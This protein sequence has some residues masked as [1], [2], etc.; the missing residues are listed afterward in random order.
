MSGLPLRCIR[1]G[2]NVSG[3]SDKTERYRITVC[4]R[5]QISCIIVILDSVISK[6]AKRARRSAA[7]LQPLRATRR[8]RR[9][10]DLVQQQAQL[11]N[12][13]HDAIV[14]RNLNCEILYWN[15]GAEATYGW[16]A[17]AVLGQVSHQL[18]STEFPEPREAIDAQVI[19][20]GRWEGEI[21]H[22]RADGTVIV[23]ASRWTLL[24][25]AGGAPQAVIEVN[26]DISRRKHLESELLEIGERERQRIG[27]DLHDGLGQHLGGSELLGRTLAAKLRKRGLP[28]AR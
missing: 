27:R 10:R 28:E 18:L 3:E 26:R 7:R 15:A 9:L 13:V 16:P 24:R 1:C 20:S 8:G 19:R 23:V 22:R 12:L 14:I 25:D 6:R 21:R 17:S 2:R 11:L 5:V 4:P